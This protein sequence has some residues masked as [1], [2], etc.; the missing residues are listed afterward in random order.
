MGTLCK[1]SDEEAWEYKVQHVKEGVFTADKENAEGYFEG[2]FFEGGK[3]EKIIGKCDG[4]VIYFLR[5]AERPRY[6]YAGT[7]DGD[8]KIIKGRRVGL[9]AFG[10][11]IQDDEEWEGTKTITFIAPRD[12]EA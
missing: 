8:D 2:V 1:T 3:Q 7:F 4:T 5:P 6:Y 11:K 10:E 9:P 12:S